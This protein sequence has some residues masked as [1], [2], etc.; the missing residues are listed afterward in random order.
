MTRLHSH[1]H[2][3]KEEE[4][5]S[6]YVA[7]VEHGVP[8]MRS[9]WVHRTWTNQGGD[10]GQGTRLADGPPSA[11]RRPYKHDIDNHGEEP[12]DPW[13]PLNSA[14]DVEVPGTPTPGRRLGSPPGTNLHMREEDELASPG[15]KIPEDLGAKKM[16]APWGTGTEKLS[17]SVR[18]PWKRWATAPNPPQKNTWMRRVQVSPEE[19]PRGVFPPKPLQPQGC[20]CGIPLAYKRRTNAP[21]GED[22]TSASRRLG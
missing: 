15:W 5:S 19:E 4:N 13:G 16:E 7:T 1:Q 12:G 22:G 2:N 3:S 20:T 14:E 6:N 8:L 18:P 17:V 11:P 9:K 10:Q 21:K